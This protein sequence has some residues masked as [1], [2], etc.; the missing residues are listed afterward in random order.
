MIQNR[1]A[2]EVRQVLFEVCMQAEDA[3]GSDEFDPVNVFFTDQD[4]E[5]GYDGATE[6]DNVMVQVDSTDCMMQEPLDF[7]WRQS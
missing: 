4:V 2:S 3:I 5:S 7:K 6:A 1:K